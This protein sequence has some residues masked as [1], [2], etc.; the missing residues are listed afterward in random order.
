MQQRCS[1]RQFQER[2]VER[3]K[4]L[5]V[6]EA[7][8]VAPSAC[9]LQPWQLIVIEDRQ[10]IAKIAPPWVAESKAPHMMVACGDH[11]QAWR[12]RDGKGFCDVDVAI[13]VDHMT[14]A[15]AELGL[16][17]CWICSFDAFRCALML[18][19]PDHLEA[20]VLLPIGYP[21]E[22]RSADRHRDER[23]PL[24]KLVAWHEEGRK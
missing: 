3:E 21:A 9:N 15:A 18:Q 8:R 19:I 10:L 24:K 23:K 17:T 11:R 14:L 2:P 6:L 13:A 12:R 1:I 7:A 16:G 22:T 20:M 4:L 5:Y